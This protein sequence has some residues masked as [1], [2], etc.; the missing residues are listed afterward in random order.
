[1]NNLTQPFPVG[2]KYALLD[3]RKDCG[4]T[5]IYLPSLC[6]VSAMGKSLPCR[7]F[8]QYGMAE[9]CVESVT[10]RVG[11]TIWVEPNFLVLVSN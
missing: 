5:P 4:M 8:N 11:E 3:C 6:F 1:M 7:D 10:G 9:L 2:S